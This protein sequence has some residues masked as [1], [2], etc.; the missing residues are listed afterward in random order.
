MLMLLRELQ[1]LRKET[2]KPVTKKPR[3]REAEKTRHHKKPRTEKPINRETKKPIN[4]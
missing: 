4:R 1:K 3:N 2:E